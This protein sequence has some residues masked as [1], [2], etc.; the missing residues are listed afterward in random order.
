MNHYYYSERNISLVYNGPPLERPVLTLENYCKWYGFYIVHT[1][2]GVEQ[3]SNDYGEYDANGQ[4]VGWHDH[5]PH[6]LLMDC[7]AEKHNLIVDEQAKEMAIGRY[8]M[9]VKG[10]YNDY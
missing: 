6:P 3:L 1:T 7:L 9:E 10:E 2:G 5:V 8:M 4:W